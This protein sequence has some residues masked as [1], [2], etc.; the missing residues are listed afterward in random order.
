MTSTAY[1]T[2]CLDDDSDEETACVVE[3][4]VIGSHRVSV[5]SVR[6]DMPGEPGPDLL[7]EIDHQEVKHTEYR[8]I[9]MLGWKKEPRYR[10]DN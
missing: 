3:F 7:A 4:E 5:V 6:V 8:I 2:V 1:M 9:R 10:G